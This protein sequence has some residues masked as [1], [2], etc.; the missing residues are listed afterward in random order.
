MTVLTGYRVIQELQASSDVVL[1]Q[2]VRETD[3]VLVIVKLLKLDEASL[4]D[5]T[6]F[7]QEY[8][9]SKSYC[10]PELLKLISLQ[11][12]D[13]YLILFYENFDGILLSNYIRN[14]VIEISEFLA[15][16]LRL[17]DA[18]EALH[19]NHI[20]HKDIQPQ[21]ILIN[22]NNYQVK[23][24]NLSAASLLSKENLSISNPNFLDGTLS[25][26]SPEQT[27]RMNRSLDY[28]TDFYSLGATF[29]E[30]L[31]NQPPFITPDPMEL[32]HCHIARVPI[33][34]HQLNS[35]VPPVVS[36]IVM[37]LLAKTAEE[38]YQSTYGL[39]ADLE[40]C[41]A[42]L[43][44]QGQISH[45]TLAQQDV[46]SQLLISQKLYGRELEV[47]QLM[48]ACDRVSQG[49]R[50]LVLVSGYSGIGKSS[51][52]QEVYKPISR[53]RG[54]FIAGKFDQFKRS[55]PYSALI[56]V[57]QDLIRQLLTESPE[58]LQAW[59]A[60]I[61]EAVGVS[62][63]T[64]IEVIPEVELIIGP[65]PTIPSL[66]PTE[67][68]NR[69]NRVFQQ[70]VSVFAQTQHLLTIFLDDLQ[71]VDLA[72]LKLMSI[73]ISDP[74]IPCLLI[75]GAYRDN[76][77]STTH[78]LVPMI[79][80]LQNTGT[81][82][83]QIT[84]QPLE[85]SH[86]N[87]LIADTLHCELE[88]SNPL[89]EV[90]YRKTAGNPFFLMQ[91]LETLYQEGL[92]YF[93]FA[94][95]CWQWNLQQIQH[96]AIPDNVVELMANKIANLAGATP[97]TLKLAACVGNR[98]EL[99]V[100]ATVNKK[101]LS[102]TA[103]DLWDALQS[104][105][106]LPLDN[107]YKLP[108]V[109]AQGEQDSVLSTVAK[110]D[111][112]F[113]HDRVQQAAYSLISEEE[114]KA[115]HLN[116][117]WLLLQNTPPTELEDNIF[118]IVNHLN[119]GCELI[120]DQ[121]EKYQLSYLNL[122]AGKKA[123]AATA[124]EAANRYLMRG[125]EFLARDSWQQQYELTLSLFAEAIESEY[126]STRFEQAIELSKTVLSQ[127]KSLLDKIPVYRS[128]IQFYASQDQARQATAMALSVLAMLGVSLP[129]NPQKVDVWVEQVWLKSALR[130]R[131]IEELS[132]L[133]EMTKADKLAAMQIISSVISPA[134]MS[135]PN[136]FAIL[137]FRSIRLSLKFGNASLSAIAYGQYGLL[138]CA[139]GDTDLGYKTGQL[140]LRLLEKF[141]TREL[142]SK[143]YF[144]FNSSIRPWKEH[145]QETIEFLLEGSQIGF[146]VGDV[147]FACYNAAFYYMHLFFVGRPLQGVAAQLARYV[148]LMA[149]LRQE[150]QSNFIQLW[151]QLV[152]ALLGELAD[153][154][155]LSDETLDEVET[156]QFLLQTKNY[157][158]IF[159]AYY[160]KLV[161]SYLT[162]NYSQAIT[163]ANLAESYAEGVAGTVVVVEHNFYFS[164]ALLARYSTAEKSEQKRILH[165]VRSQQSKMKKWAN[166]CPE[167]Y[168]PKYELVEAEINRS[169]GQILEAMAAYDRAIQAARDY[170]YLQIEA[171]ANEL[172]AEFY[173][174]LGKNPI[175]YIYLEAAH[176]GFVRWGAM[177]KVADLEARYP[178]LFARLAV[179]QSTSISNP[180]V[181][182]S[183]TAEIPRRL[184][185]TTVFKASQALS[186]EIILNTLLERFMHLL[187][188]NAGAQKG[189]F[190]TSEANHDVVEAQVTINGSESIVLGSE[191]IAAG[192]SLP[193][194]LINYVKRTRESVILSNAAYDGRF[195]SDPYIIQ[196]QAKSVL[197]L[198]IV[199]QGKLTG[200]L[201]LE[202]NLVT[203]AFTPER[204]EILKL[205][206]AQ[207]AI[208]IEN[209]KLYTNLERQV[210]ERTAQLQQSLNF[211]ATLKRI[212]DR[213]RDSL[214]E[215]QILETTVQELA[216]VLGVLCCNAGIYDHEHQTSTVYYEYT[217]TIPS[218]RGQVFSIESESGI[219][220]QLLQGQYFQF[221]H[222]GQEIRIRHQFAMLV[223]PIK[224]SES[225][226]GDLW[227]FK[228]KEDA[229]D[230]QEVRLAQQVANQCAIAIR[231]A[232]L[233]QTAQAQ[234]QVLEELNQLKDDFLSTVSHELRTPI[235]NMKMAIHMLRQI[236]DPDRQQR[237]LSILQYECAREAELINDLLDLQRL[238][239]GT[240]SFD[241]EVI[242]MQ[243]WMPQILEAFYERI[244]SRQQ[245][246]QVTIAPD[247]P[248]LT[249]DLASLGRIVAELL[250]NACKYTP[251]Q[252]QITVS[253]NKVETQ[254][255]PG[256]DC[257]SPA[258]ILIQVSN[259]GV[260]I[261]A[262]ALPKVF[263]KFYRVP[264]GD[265]WKQGGTGLGLALAQK[266]AEH[267]GG[268]V[269][270]ESTANLTSFTVELPI[271]PIELLTQ[272][273]E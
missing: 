114:K 160:T 89:T 259:S 30:M 105:L 208:S 26:M 102:A 261:P 49:G 194:T 8:E 82:V 11:R 203:G 84:L 154:Y 207:V 169:L 190:I 248:P 162:R 79:E 222:I 144:L 187:I 249:T 216:Q 122:I 124:Y 19:Q 60:K 86:I 185:L 31:T 167:N 35:K 121:S 52:V 193:V 269:R 201:Y 273:I 155:R 47:A 111:Y 97:D 27:G 15:I 142:K 139:S 246:L 46:T 236:P 163:Y 186:K 204:L 234:V 271:Q 28:R 100:L 226:L 132:N 108:Q 202:N 180:S 67:S 72:S 14:E 243:E 43:Q 264:G 151:R 171:L 220:A 239:A 83:N 4:Q 152:L 210:Q 10:I 240:K 20:I 231:Q 64:I 127:A 242:Q 16:A 78:P 221:C 255:E 110:I 191:A 95:G 270:V 25:Y 129:Q 101:S 12:Q 76:E 138:L 200:I 68:Q 29:Y 21:N 125:I 98:F 176:Y 65:Q 32:V 252:E 250:N 90:A 107:S 54:Y 37:K 70:L 174:S 173:F 33:S 66:S 59:K 206:T 1:Y 170:G 50:E 137:V 143:V 75:I 96:Q 77:V 247:L 165:Q 104:G 183:S 69:F 258:A 2:A 118:E 134:Y 172:A 117:G 241:P 209:A 147:E 178:R 112:K 251:P 63:Q 223:C 23:I 58:Q 17:A 228:R 120:T 181:A 131:Q 85:S 212:T 119:L 195:I 189:L 179:S 136:L 218:A 150:F 109:L 224:D 213:V 73:L 128:Q 166:D 227:L 135:A 55:I 232:R 24:T 103:N 196:Q 225:T 34:P 266:L 62:G 51:L 214:D 141:E 262:E 140:A 237:Y 133:P 215:D 168:Q 244:Q 41:L 56:Q 44:E 197:C 18:L 254:L 265:R 184:D 36:D 256:A 92:L 158:S 91:F 61:L 123:K 217:T 3:Q 94:A 188:E 5:I 40:N 148:E 149:K 233:Y 157:S 113:L 257:C 182:A 145:I 235:S 198:P 260:E 159:Y 164:L 272:P 71:W 87:Q 153:E 38:R 130:R 106:V 267:L 115:T 211:E 156:M 7:R 219:Y 229:F 99:S 238:V 192:A 93:D 53:Q 253:I 146:E 116:L 13:N 175:A 80:E 245:N 268:T 45:F 161:L 6:R 230:E 57:F 74:D 88:R 263:E 42:Q 22:P 48:E 81:S 177:A 39:K 126:L 205:L 9:I 199:Y